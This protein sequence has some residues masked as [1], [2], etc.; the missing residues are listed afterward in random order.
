MFTAQKVMCTDLKCHVS[1]AAQEQAAKL[2]KA[3]PFGKAGVFGRKPNEPSNTYLGA[4]DP[5]AVS[6]GFA[7]KYELTYVQEYLFLNGEHTLKPVSV[8]FTA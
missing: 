6:A 2:A 5:I 8:T 1:A 3:G 7:D 4:W